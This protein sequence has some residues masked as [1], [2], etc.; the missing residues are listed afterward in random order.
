MLLRRGR[1]LRFGHAP[2]SRL[3]NLLWHRSLSIVLLSLMYG[4]HELTA[5]RGNRCVDRLYEDTLSM[6]LA[7]SQSLLLLTARRSSYFFARLAIKYNPPYLNH[8]CRVLCDIDAVLVACCRDV[9]DHIAIQ[10][11]RLRGGCC[12]HVRA[13]TR[14]RTEWAGVW[15]G[16]SV[17]CNST[18][19]YSCL[20]RP[21]RWP[22]V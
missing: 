5:Q 8:F 22:R 18:C 13:K 4:L 1:T 9:D 17:L 15:S 3:S 6:K 21:L 10:L 14:E 11:W 19:K 20:Q 12:C 7:F 16:R 2:R